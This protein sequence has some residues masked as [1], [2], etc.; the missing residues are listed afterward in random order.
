MG[1]NK[2]FVVKDGVVEARDVKMGDR[3]E[4]DVEILEG[5]EDGEA[6]A[7]T[8][9]AKLDT[10]VKVR[11]NNDPPKQDPARAKKAD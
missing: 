3:F 4:T 5:V 2:A 9:L 8:Q 1:S 10:G 6:V 7:M 11:V